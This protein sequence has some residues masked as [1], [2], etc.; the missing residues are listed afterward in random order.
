LLGDRYRLYGTAPVSERGQIVIPKEARDDLGVKPG[1]K[2][3]VIG[4]VK[5]NLLLLVK[6]DFIK[7]LAYKV[8]ETIEK[9]ASEGG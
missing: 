2:L 8:L 9:G 6:S 7:D 5:N 3:L 4:D 1:D